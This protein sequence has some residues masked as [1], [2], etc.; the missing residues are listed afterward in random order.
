MLL[1]K[2][3]ATN[4]ISSLSRHSSKLSIRVKLSDPSSSSLIRPIIIISYKTH[5]H[6]LLSDPSSSSLIR[7]III[8]SY[9]TH[10][11]HLLSDPSSSSL[12]RPIHFY[13]APV[14][15]TISVIRLRRLQVI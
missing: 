12:I 5:H 3:K 9:Q 2:L 10:H 15:I 6:H 8:T 1:I 13:A 11:H 4:A 14:W 7:P